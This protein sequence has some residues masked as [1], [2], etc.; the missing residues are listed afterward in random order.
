MKVLKVLFCFFL[1]MTFFSQLKAQI[2][3]PPSRCDIWMTF[4]ES[5]TT[6]TS[7]PDS[8]YCFVFTVHSST[9][10]YLFL[11]H[12]HCSEASESLV[13]SLSST[14]C[15]GPDSCGPTIYAPDAYRVDCGV[16]GTRECK[17]GC[18]VIIGG[19]KVIIDGEIVIDGDN[20]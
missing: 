7:N 3:S 17:E 14:L 13:T 10:K 19:G 2:I 11:E 20:G 5:S 1:L 8:N 12:D 9:P 16:Q 6:T 4:Y 15:F 18:D